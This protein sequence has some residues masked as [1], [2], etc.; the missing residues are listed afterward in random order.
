MDFGLILD[1]N[2]EYTHLG[3]SCGLPN[4]KVSLSSI[5]GLNHS[6]IPI[7]KLAY[8]DC[9]NTFKQYVDVSVDNVEPVSPSVILFSLKYKQLPLLS[10][11]LPL[12]HWSKFQLTMFF[13]S[14]LLTPSS[15]YV[16]L[17]KVFQLNTYLV[18]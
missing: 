16:Y 2:I 12:F 9:S 6:N 10:L 5:V 1:I 4:V 8:E 17:D 18:S 11:L 7:E 3:R 13:F 15:S 14:D